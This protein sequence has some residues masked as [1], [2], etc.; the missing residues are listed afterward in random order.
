MLFSGCVNHLRNSTDAL[1]CSSVP[2][3]TTMPAP[4]C[5]ET[6]FVPSKYG[7]GRTRIVMSW[8]S[9]LSVWT[10]FGK[11]DALEHEPT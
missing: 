3:V 9:P 2:C 10:C 4:C 1:I 7:H 11:K 5:T 6:G 8:L